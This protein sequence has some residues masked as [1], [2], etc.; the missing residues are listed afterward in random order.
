[1]KNDNDSTVTLAQ[2]L[3]D[4]KKEQ[5]EKFSLETVNLAELQRR[6]GIS[7]AKLRR[8]KGKVERLV[9]YVKDNF[10]AGR[11]FVNVSD[12][13]EQALQW[14]NDKNFVFRKE[15]EGFSVVLHQDECKKICLPLSVNNP[16]IMIYLFPERKIS[17]DGF[18]TYEGRRF[19]VPYSYGLK[20]VRINRTERLISIYS[21]DMS[22]CLVTHDV[23]WSRKDSFCK[24]QYVSTAQPEEHPTAPVKSIVQQALEISNDD[25]FSKFNFE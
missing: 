22:R 5:G 20:I 14:S 24:D 15:I 16:E 1:M 10:I 8:L 13:N 17:F 11:Q 4:I 2:A 23:T 7:R 25:S 19:G 18:V 21:D 6:T 12:L 9:R 3:Q